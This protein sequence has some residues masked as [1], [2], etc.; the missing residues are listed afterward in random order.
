MS[1][2]DAPSLV[3]TVLQD[4]YK[5]TRLI[6][7]GAMG[8]VYEAVQNRLGKR[9]AVKVMAR[10]LATNTEALARFRREVQVTSQLAHPHIIQVSDF[11][12]APTGEP[13]LV[14][15]YLEGQDLEQRIE[16]V[17]R[18][19]LPAA[20]HII[21]Q[22]SS[23]L[24][25][26]HAEG[27]VHRDLKP[28][29]VFLVKVPGEIDFVKVVD[30]GISKVLKRSATKLTRAQ[31]VVGTPEYMS[32]EQAAGKVD[33]VDHR[34]DQWALACIAWRMIWGQQPFVGPDVN[35]VLYQVMNG[36]PPPLGTKAGNTPPEVEQVL[37]RALS[38]RQRD[39][40]PTIT[41]FSRAFEAAA[42]APTPAP[43][44]KEKVVEKK[45]RPATPPAPVK[46]LS[47]ALKD[48][49]LRATSVWLPVKR[50]PPPRRRRKLAW[51]S[52]A[53]GAT[54]AIGAAILFA[55]GRFPGQATGQP[56]APASAAAQPDGTPTVVPLHSAKASGNKGAD[57]RHRR[58]TPHR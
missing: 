57:Q 19:P 25:V 4:T 44:P 7:A 5:L 17:G 23:A 15:E 30:F 9:V 47:R 52:A 28:A 35:T 37:R 22:L 29:N 2:I 14:M 27:I 18:L 1:E 45:P 54:L 56:A 50:K 41:A 13:Y 36:E 24:A 11:G 46:T 12:T 40:F 6:G 38:K 20:V 3:G 8:A 43:V 26:T 34:S 10:E 33:D 58:P 21:K 16:R 42:A 31:M 49:G 32:P 39:R 55:S 51:I 48:F 53:V